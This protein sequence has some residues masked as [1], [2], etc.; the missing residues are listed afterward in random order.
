MQT[1]ILKQLFL[2][3]TENLKREIELYSSDEKLWIIDGNGHIKNSG[4]NLCYHLIG[5]MNHFIGATLLHTGYVRNRD[6]EFVV[7]DISKADLLKLLEDLTVLLNKAFT[8]LT[9]DDLNKTY[10][11]DFMGT[12]TTGFYLTRFLCHLSYHLGQVNYHRRLL[13][14]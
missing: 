9:D 8:Q 3:E 14:I 13:D 1:A 6:A 7:K 4:G 2:F 5:S 11:Y 10:P 12:N